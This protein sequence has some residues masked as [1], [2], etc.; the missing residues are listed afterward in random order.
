MAIL[1]IGGVVMPIIYFLKAADLQNVRKKLIGIYILNVTD[2]AFTLLLLKTG[3]FAEGNTFMQ[4]IVSN[5]VLSIF[6]KVIIALGL[7]MYAYYRVQFATE[8]QLRQCNYFASGC[9]IY[10][11]LINLSHL[12]WTGIYISTITT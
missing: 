7:I 6:I 9:L 10:Y 8:K 1:P 5:E 11:G 3:M 12:V 4:N 2:I